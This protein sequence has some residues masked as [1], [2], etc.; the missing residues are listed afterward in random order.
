MADNYME[1]S[2]VIENLTPEEAAWLDRQL[3]IDANADCPAYAKLCI[4][5]GYAHI[6]I[7]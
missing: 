5:Q 7:M 4:T 6:R 2:E 3:A 1:F